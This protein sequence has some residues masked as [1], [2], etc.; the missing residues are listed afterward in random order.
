MDAVYISG[1]LVFDSRLRDEGRLGHAL[2][3]LPGEDEESLFKKVLASVG[4]IF[5]PI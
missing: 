4:L 5:G 2:A 3:S 1:I